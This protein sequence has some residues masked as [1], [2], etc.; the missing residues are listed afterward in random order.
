MTNN[1]FQVLSEAHLDDILVQNMQNLVVVMLSATNCVPCKSIKPK[2]IGL[3]R[4]HPD[5][6]FVYIDTNDYA[7]VK[8]KYFEKFEFTP[9]FVFF[10]NN[11][12]IAFIEGGYETQLISVLEEVKQ[13]INK[14][15]KELE[16]SQKTNPVPQVNMNNTTDLL[17]KKIELLGILK[18]LVNKG[19]ILSKTYSLNSELEDIHFE[20]RF[21]TDKKFRDM[22]LSFRDLGIVAA[23]QAQTVPVQEKKVPINAPIVVNT[24]PVVERNHVEDSDKKQELVRQIQEL[25]ALNQKMQM[26]NFQKLQQL[27]KIKQMKEQQESQQNDHK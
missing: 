12:R 27:N 16:I 7:V 10:F 21:H 26:Q 15:K 24:T 2:F 6:F 13:K 3:S 5:V 22:V 4:K 11:T 17:Q 18:D 23:P 25:N 1:I 20:I 14:K 9:T 8:N 19:V